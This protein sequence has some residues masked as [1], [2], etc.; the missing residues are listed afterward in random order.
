MEQKKIDNLVGSAKE[1]FDPRQ[2]DKILSNA[3]RDAFNYAQEVKHER[4]RRNWRKN[5]KRD[6]RRH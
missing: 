5:S 6:N 3:K 1:I 2:V 4:K